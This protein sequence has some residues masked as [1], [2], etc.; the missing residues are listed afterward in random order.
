MGESCLLDFSP[1]LAQTTSLYTQNHL[2]S[3]GPTHNILGSRTSVS[4]QEKSGRGNFS[5]EIPS[6]KIHQRIVSS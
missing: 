2:P 1:C 4:N 3:G 6:S 5:V